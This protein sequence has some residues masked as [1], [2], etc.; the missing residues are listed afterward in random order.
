MA[1]ASSA[2]CSAAARPRTPHGAEPPHPARF[3][4]DREAASLQ[5]RAGEVRRSG[6]AR[7]VRQGGQGA[8]RYATM[9]RQVERTT[10]RGDVVVSPGSSSGL[11]RSVAGAG[12]RSGLPLAAASLRHV[13]TYEMI[14]VETK[15]ARPGA[16]LHVDDC[17]IRA[18]VTQNL[19]CSRCTTLWILAPDDARSNGGEQECSWHAV[20]LVLV[21]RE[22]S[23]HVGLQSGC[24]GCG[25]WMCLGERNDLSR[26]SC[27]QRSCQVRASRA[28]AT[29]VIGIARKAT[30][31]SRALLRV[32]G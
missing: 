4:L 13:Y 15:S 31:V 17:Q 5:G 32:H 14:L 8:D 11:V 27:R 16:G 30:R 7:L 12:L 6:A 1:V 19:R 28:F 9:P 24:G 21:A 22:V 3:V 20:C 29:G 25:F 23:G 10:H 2:P 18:I 26:T